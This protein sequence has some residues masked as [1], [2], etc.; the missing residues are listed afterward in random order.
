[1][2]HN[3]LSTPVTY[4]YFRLVINS[5]V[6]SKDR[7]TIFYLA[8]FGTFVEPDLVKGAIS[9]NVVYQRMT[10]ESSVS[11]AGNS[12]TEI[13]GLRLTITPQSSFSKVELNYSIF[14]E[15]SITSYGFVVSRTVGGT[16]TFFTPGGNDGIGDMTFGVY[17]EDHHSTPQTATFS[18]IDEPNTTGVVV[19]KVYG[20][21]VLQVALEI[22]I[23]IELLIM[24]LVMDL[25]TVFP[26]VPLKNFQPSRIT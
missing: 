12:K 24:E 19:Y 1:M 10:E 6:G 4:Q 21:F 5:L 16:E 13:E 9:A 7:C 8:F 14:H 18:M 20:N 22:Y 3:T 2:K 23:L 17:E 26:Q 11:L 15:I 25:N